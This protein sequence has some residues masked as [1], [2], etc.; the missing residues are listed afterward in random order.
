MRVR[1]LLLCFCA[2]PIARAV[3]S[4]AFATGAVGSLAACA[5][6][7]PVPQLPE[8]DEFAVVGP[9]AGTDWVEYRVTAAAGPA[10]V[11]SWHDD[12]PKPVVVLFQGSACYPL[13]TVDPDGRYHGTTVFEDVMAANRTRVH[14][15]L[16]EKRGVEPLRF[17]A[18]STHAEQSALFQR[19]GEGEC[20]AEF[21]QQNSKG[22]RVAD[23][24]SAVQALARQ[25]WVTRVIVGGHSEG[26][27][28]AAGVVNADDARTVAAAGLFSSATI[29]GV[30]GDPADREAFAA[31]VSRQSHIVDAPDDEMIDG[32]PA[33]R[34]KSYTIEATPL[35]DLRDSTTP[36]FIAHGGREPDIR[37]ADAFVLEI[38]RLRPKHPLRYVVVPDGDHGFAGADGA[39]RMPELFADF[40][41]WALDPNPPTGVAVLP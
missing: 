1:D 18:G 24:L 30:D 6:A 33:R 5:P 27:R 37:R 35:D 39:P 40:L 8:A 22:V 23:A 3:R 10:R 36:L 19:L 32:L 2:G 15:A 41:G 17:P 13:F 20:N 7:A 21:Y 4:L 26:T 28:V 12:T 29:Q 38:L 16:V 34:W 31:A 14:F 9:L 11:Y 25:P